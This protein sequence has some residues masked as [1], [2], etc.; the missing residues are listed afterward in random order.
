MN[1]EC[2]P[3]RSFKCNLATIPQLKKSRARLLPQFILW[4]YFKMYKV[5][6]YQNL[7][8][9]A[10]VKGCIKITQFSIVNVK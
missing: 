8:I 4:N 1:T 7:K 9:I 5:L 3:E 10:I 6:V 2:W